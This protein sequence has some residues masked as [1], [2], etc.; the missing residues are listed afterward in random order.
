MNTTV[1]WP[2]SEL[3]SRRM[4]WAGHVARSSCWEKQR[5]YLSRHVGDL[6]DAPTTRRETG[7]CVC[8]RPCAVPCPLRGLDIPKHTAAWSVDWPREAHFLIAALSRSA[9][10]VPILRFG[11]PPGSSSC[12]TISSSIGKIEG[13]NTERWWE[14]SSWTYECHAR[15][16]TDYRFDVSRATDGGE[17]TVD[18][19]SVTTLWRSAVAVH[20]DGARLCLWTAATNGPTVYLLD[21][22]V[23]TAL[24]EWH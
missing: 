16:E 8:T 1:M 14:R 22:W 20:V 17:R 5:N 3:K 15:N 6:D 13:D 19:T 21:I 7:C 2:V 18:C 9:T 10:S 23:W 24:V 12:S 4:R 11:L